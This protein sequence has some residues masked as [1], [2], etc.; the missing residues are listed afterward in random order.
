MSIKADESAH[1]HAFIHDA[2]RFTLYNRL[3]IEGAPLQ[4]YFSALVFAPE[5]SM[6]RKQFENQISHWIRRLPKTQKNWSSLL[7][8]L[9]GHS[10]FVSAVTFS[11]DGKLM[12]SGSHDHTV[13]L[14]DS[15]TG[16]PRGTLKGH[17]HSVNAVAFSPNGKLVASGS[18]DY[19][20]RLWDSATGVSRCTLEGHSGSVSVVAFSPDGKLVAYGSYDG[21]VRLW[22]WAT[23]VLRGTLECHGANRIRTTLK[24]SAV[25]FSPDGKLVA[26]GSGDG[27][28]RLWDSATGASLRMFQVDTVISELSFSKEG[29]YLETN[30]GLLSIQSIFT[31]AFPL[32]PQ[33]PCNIFVKEHWVA[34][35]MENL[36]WLPSD[37]RPTCAAFRSNIFVLGHSSGRVTFMEF[38]SS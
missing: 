18:Y 6:V 26:S 22:D 11:P 25:A 30:R 17:S 32:Q 3:I 5:T 15:A 1:L 8:T 37:Y 24:V 35:N 19:T 20:V 14:W 36:L 33:L 38:S 10:G 16:A 7:Q 2:K 28:V 29:P 31:G 21:T 34:Q 12:A 4:I 23:G 27:A 9:E 13:R